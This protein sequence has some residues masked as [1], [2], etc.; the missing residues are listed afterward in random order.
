MPTCA[1]TVDEWI[2]II[3]QK[4]AKKENGCW[5]FT[6]RTDG[7]G[8]GSIFVG[9]RK[10][11]NISVH[12]LMYEKFIGPIP[13]GKFVLHSCDNPPCCNPEH[14]FLGTHQDNMKDMRKKGRNYRT[15]GEKSGMSKL[16]TVQINNIR[17]SKL[18]GVVLA[19]KYGVSKSTISLIRN[20]KSRVYG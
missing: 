5:E 16:T 7:K 2:E 6:S 13:E 9:G 4:V 19:K 18:N 12:R 20:N 15:I 11:K 14:L 17:K 8:Y 10:G 1:K 3:L